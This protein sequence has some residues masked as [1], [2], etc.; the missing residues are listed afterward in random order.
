[1]E[2]DRSPDE[3]AAWPADHADAWD[4]LYAAAREQAVAEAQAEALC[5]LRVM[6]RSKDE[7]T[8]Q[9]AI[10]LINSMGARRGKAE[11]PAKPM[12]EL[13]RL[14]HHVENLDETARRKFFDDFR[15]RRRPKRHRDDGKL[16]PSGG[17]RTP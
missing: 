4:R 6:L 7:K 11:P 9:G 16:P 10:K 8:C 12:S 17:D 13:V 1:M 3:C 5:A 2:L 15:P 14:A